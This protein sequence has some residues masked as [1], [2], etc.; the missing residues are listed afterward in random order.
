MNDLFKKAPHL[1]STNQI[2]ISFPFDYDTMDSYKQ[3]I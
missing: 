2:N 3:G 1:D